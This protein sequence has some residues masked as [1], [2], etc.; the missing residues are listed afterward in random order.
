MSSEKRLKNLE[1]EKVQKLQIG[2]DG[3]QKNPALL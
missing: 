1:D 2:I 3:R